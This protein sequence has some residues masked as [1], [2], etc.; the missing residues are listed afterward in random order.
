LERFLNLVFLINLFGFYKSS[1]TCDK[2][3]NDNSYLGTEGVQHIKANIYNI[4]FSQTHGQRDTCG[5]MLQEQNM[6]A[7]IHKRSVYACITYV[8]GG[9]WFLANACHTTLVAA[10]VHWPVIGLHVS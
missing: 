1:Q 7:S 3:T 2:H 5:D 8:L 4:N 10:T 9:V 6:R